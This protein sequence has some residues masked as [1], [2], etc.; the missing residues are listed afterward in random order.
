MNLERTKGIKNETKSN[1]LLSF[2]LNSCA[3]AI[4]RTV[5]RDCEFM[6]LAFLFLEKGEAS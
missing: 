2:Y 4:P 3:R 5:P 1:A 6:K